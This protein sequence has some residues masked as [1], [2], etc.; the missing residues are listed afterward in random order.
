MNTAAALSTTMINTRTTRRSLKELCQ[1]AID[2]NAGVE[3][4]EAIECLS[5]DYGITERQRQALRTRLYHI[6]F[7]YA[8][9]S[10]PN[11][12]RRLHTEFGNMKPLKSN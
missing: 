6:A 7:H 12:W 3:Q 1:L 5:R 2:A 8:L 10:D 9:K 4:V 11:A